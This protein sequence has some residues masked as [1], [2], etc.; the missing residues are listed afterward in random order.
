MRRAT[1]APSPAGLARAVSGTGPSTIGGGSGNL[2]QSVGDAYKNALDDTY[3]IAFGVDVE[4]RANAVGDAEVEVS[5]K[6]HTGCAKFSARFGADALRFTLASMAGQGRDIKLDEKIA[7]VHKHLTGS[8]RGTLIA[9]PLSMLF[10]AVLG[11]LLADFHAQ[12]KP[13]ASVC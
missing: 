11:A 8:C 7:V 3:T 5:E 2:L 12:D 1:P 10:A 13:I 6:P 4:R 9:T